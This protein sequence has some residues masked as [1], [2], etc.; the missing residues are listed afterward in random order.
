MKNSISNNRKINFTDFLFLKD[1]FH[2]IVPAMK[3]NKK[4]IKK[5]QSLKI[6]INHTI[7]III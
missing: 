3:K 6:Q 7:A 1:K 5:Q 2:L 4:P